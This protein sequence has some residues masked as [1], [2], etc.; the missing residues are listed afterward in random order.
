LVWAVGSSPNP[1]LETI[2]CAKAHGRLL[3]NDSLELEGWAGV[4]ALGD[5]AAV[6]DPR[7]GQFHPPTAQ[8]G[9]RQAKVVAHNIVA[10]VRGTE[11]KRF[12]YSAFAQLAAIGRRTGVAR[13]FGVNFSGFVAWWIWRTIYLC[14]LPRLEKKIRVA[15][16]WTLD[17]VFS[18]DLVQ[19][20]EIRSSAVSGREVAITQLSGRRE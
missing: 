20:L 18:K 16:D 8:H 17:L 5:C 7:T 9:L 14:K 11:K 19:F 10:A 12:D 6:P 4:W 15:F 3:V 1:L 13:I 2:P